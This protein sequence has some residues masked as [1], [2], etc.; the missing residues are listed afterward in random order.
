MSDAVCLHP[1]NVFISVDSRHYRLAVELCDKLAEAADGGAEF[2]V[3]CHRFPTADQQIHEWE[4]SIRSADIVL[5]V[6]PSP[7]DLTPHC[8][9]QT[10][11]SSA[12]AKPVFYLHSGSERLPGFESHRTVHVES[13]EL[14]EF[15]H[16]LFCNTPTLGASQPINSHLIDVS[17]R[18]LAGEIREL[19]PD[20][21]A[22]ITL[23]DLVSMARKLEA[24]IFTVGRR[25]DGW[26]SD[27]LRT[28]G[29]QQLASTIEAIEDEANEQGLMLP[30]TVEQAFDSAADKTEVRTLHARWGRIRAD[31][32]DAIDSHDVQG[33]GAHVAEWSALNERFLELAT[34]RAAEL[35]QK[36]T[37]A[38][39]S[40]AA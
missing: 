14:P 37:G 6:A 23:G 30:K 25:A 21:R 10:G 16:S 32:F 38:V 12:I 4:D 7:Q 17:L 15:L 24:E 3:G 22:R 29:C 2:S 11:Y 39:Q 13:G 5:M 31:L 34:R 36:T 9:W 20:A 27:H 35:G 1:V 33:V 28:A 19:M 18:R 26:T 40:R 8:A